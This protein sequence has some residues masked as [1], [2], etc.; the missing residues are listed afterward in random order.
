MFN[1][2]F[3]L[4]GFTGQSQ[5]GVPSKSGEVKKYINNSCAPL[6]IPY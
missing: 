1:A 4:D 2:I 3:R 5:I 6:Y